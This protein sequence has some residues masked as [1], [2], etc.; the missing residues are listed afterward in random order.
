[1][2]GE[3]ILFT[4]AVRAREKYRPA[5]WEK[6]FVK[7]L[8]HELPYVREVAL[9]SLPLP[10]PKAARALLPRLLGDSN[11]DVQIAACKVAEKLKAREFTPAV[12]AALRAAKEQ[13]HLYAAN[14]AAHALG[15]ER[16]RVRIFVSRLDDETVAAWCR[17]HLV[18]SVL[19]G[20]SGYGSPTKLEGTT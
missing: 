4:T 3:L 20:T 10:P 5:G 15:T 2:P 6:V 19:S 9:E 16:E 7:A 12:L 13:W 8:R 1:T 11:I 18:S 17:G 14:N